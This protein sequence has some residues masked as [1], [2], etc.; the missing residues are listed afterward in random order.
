[1][2]TLTLLP[3]ASR[4]LICSALTLG[5]AFTLGTALTLGITPLGQAM[6]ANS[7]TDSAA[8]PNIETITVTYRDPLDYALYQHTTEMLS[9]FR[10]EIR[11]DIGIQARN[12]LMEMAKAQHVNRL[13]L[14]QVQASNKNLAFVWVS[15]SAKANR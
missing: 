3:I 14:A 7:A 2:K 8:S 15:P 12:S 10:L 11:E 1:M 6:E 5:T 4:L 9:A 13:N